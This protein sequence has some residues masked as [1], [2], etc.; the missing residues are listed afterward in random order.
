M[1]KN[2]LHTTHL[3]LNINASPQLETHKLLVLETTCIGTDVN[4]LDS[5]GVTPLHLALSR[6]RIARE[7]DD[8]DG[9]PLSRKRDMMQI[10]EMIQSY[11]HLSSCSDETDELEKLAGKLS[12]SETTEQV[13]QSQPTNKLGV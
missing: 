4:A 11:L 3:N 2:V 13:R 12:L 8:Q 5:R 6:L 10:V 9:L 7:C 1:S